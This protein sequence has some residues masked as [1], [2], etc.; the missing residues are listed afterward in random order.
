M[1]LP[2]YCD[3][4]AC[5]GRA[6]ARTLATAIGQRKND[7][8]QRAAQGLEVRSPEILEANARD[9]VAAK[10]FELTP[11]QVDRLRLT[12]DRIRA[13]AAGI[14]EVVALPDPVGRVLDSSVRPN[15][16]LVEKIG[17]PLGVIF[18]IYE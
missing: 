10:T 1:D 14:R 7:W 6:A 9:V 16:L 4:L 12:P 11:A 5:R 17:V 3:D 2:L 8:L 18:F 13:A 15:G